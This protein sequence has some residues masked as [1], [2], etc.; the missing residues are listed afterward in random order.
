M[1]TTSAKSPRNFVL[2]PMCRSKSKVL[3]SEFGGLQT[4]KCQNGHT[5]EHD[6]WIADRR[7]WAGIV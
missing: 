7:F 1:K 3:R 6:K 2:C 4:R 5:F